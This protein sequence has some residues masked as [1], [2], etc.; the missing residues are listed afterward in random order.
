MTRPLHLFSR[1][2]ILLFIMS[3][4]TVRPVVQP[5]AAVSSLKL[6]GQ[7]EIPFNKTFRN[8]TVGGLSGIDY[9]A[10]MDRY[11]LICDDRSDKNPARYYTA[12]ISISAS[13]IDTVEFTGVNF[14]LQPDGSMYPN[15]KQDRLRTPDPESIRFDPSGGQLV[16]TSEGERILKQND[17]V[18]VDPSIIRIKKNGT[19]VSSFAIPANMKMQAAEKGPRVNGV[20][21]GMSFADNY[22]TLFVNVEEPLLEDGPRADLVDNNAYIRIFRFAAATQKNTAQYVYKLAPIAYPPSPASGFKVN[23][24]AEILSL[25]N[26]K[27]LT[28]ERSFSTGRLQNSIKI[29]IAD[30]NGAT[31]VSGISSL[32]GNDRFIPASKKLLLDMDKL[33]VYTDNIEGVT[34]GP[35]LPN[36]HKTLLFVS[37]N[38]FSLVQKQQLLLFEVME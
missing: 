3:C 12:R 34:F 9:D 23:G 7:Y 11:F 36:G 37:D 20:L 27:I 16:W 38:N 8:T 2:T 10:R 19:Y 30:L 28:I 13:G 21:E 17:T 14:L 29:F 6:I 22:K 18:L 32:R 35:V 1:L 4:A 5:V 25:G 24:V 26:E 15:N 33:G 31:D